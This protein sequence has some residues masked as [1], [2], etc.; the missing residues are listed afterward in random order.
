M[1]SYVDYIVAIFIQAVNLG[2][3]LNALVIWKQKKIRN[4]LDND[5]KTNIFV[6]RSHG[7]FYW[8]ILALIHVS[9]KLD[10]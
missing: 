9:I 8:I 2:R 6:K 1:K 10:R 5:L 7:G 3:F 4:F